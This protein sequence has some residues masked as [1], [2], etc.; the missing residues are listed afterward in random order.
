[1][2]TPI[3]ELDTVMLSHA[4]SM[5]LELPIRW[6]H[7]IGPEI[8]HDPYWP[9]EW[10]PFNP[11]QNIAD[12]APYIAPRG[13]EIS[14]LRRRQCPGHWQAQCWQPYGIG[15]GETPQLAACRAVV[16]AEYGEMYEV[17]IFPQ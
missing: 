8:V 14:P 6:N 2:K 5:A 9:D 1:M 17:P 10:Y 15:C 4:F 7:M 13:I 16:N 11:A 3:D 12:L